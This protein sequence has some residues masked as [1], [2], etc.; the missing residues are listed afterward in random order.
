MMSAEPEGQARAAKRASAL[1]FRAM[2]AHS[3]WRKIDSKILVVAKL[4][5]S[6]PPKVFERVSRGVLSCAPISGVRGQRR[7]YQHLAPWHS[8][9]SAAALRHSTEQHYILRHSTVHTS[10]Q[11]SMLH[12]LPLC[13]DPCGRH[14]HWLSNVSRAYHSNEADQLTELTRS[15]IPGNKSMDT[16]QGRAYRPVPAQLSPIYLSSSSP[17]E[18][19]PH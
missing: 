7:N 3:C 17:V 8:A 2:L 9:S 15:D 16:R 18:Q 1:S 6:A 13:H 14:I 12:Q 4:N 19:T 5:N 10:S 11:Y